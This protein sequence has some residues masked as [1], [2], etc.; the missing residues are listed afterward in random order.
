MRIRAAI[1]DDA[2]ALGHVVVESWLAAHRGQM[3]DEA[4]Q[5][6]VDEWTPEVSAQGWARVLTDQVEH[7]G[8]RDVVLVAEDDSGALDAVVYGTA[9]DDDH[10]GPTAEITAL[11]VAPDCRRLGI[12]AAL[13][14]AAATEL[15]RHG[16]SSVRLDVL[17]ANAAARGFYAAMGGQEIGS[18][19]FDEEGFPLPVTVYGWSDLAA[20]ADAKS[21]EVTVEDDPAQ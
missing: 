14:R 5:K 19:T 7:A 13:L 10:S 1:V 18:G 9:A 2:A 3:P 4:W 15:A 20:L 6:R 11:Y 21:A 12:G 8:S 17:T 16:F